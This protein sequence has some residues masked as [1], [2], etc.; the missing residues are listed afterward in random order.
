M[1]NVHLSPSRPE[2]HIQWDELLEKGLVTFP[3]QEGEAALLGLFQNRPLLCIHPQ[4][5]KSAHPPAMSFLS[6]LAQTM[7]ENKPSAM[8]CDFTGQ[9][10]LPFPASSTLLP[11]DT[12]LDHIH[13][14][15]SLELHTLP[16]TKI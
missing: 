3:L 8:P 7:R 1:F 12:T 6:F 15:Q 2:Q 10:S 9:A 13:S 4:Q 5:W 11:K 16:I 14:S